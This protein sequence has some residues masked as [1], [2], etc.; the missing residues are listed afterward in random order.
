MSLGDLEIVERRP[1]GGGCISRTERIRVKSGREFCLKQH[2]GS[3]GASMLAA[4]AAGLRALWSE[5]GPRVPAVENVWSEGKTTYL[6]MEYIE[7]GSRGGSFFRDFGMKLARLHKE[8]K[9]TRFGFHMDNYIGSTPQPNTWSDTWISFFAEHRLG[10]QIRLARTK[11]LADKRMSE[12]VERI[13]S[14]LDSLLVEPEQASVLH[15]DLWGGN[16]LVDSAGTAVIIDPAVYYGHREADLAMTELFGG[17]SP[18]FYRAYQEEWPLQPGY[19]ERSDLYNLYHMLNHLNI[20]GGGYAG[21][22]ARICRKY[23]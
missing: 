1:L 4:E 15:G 8:R 9:E 12:D 23:R 11:G 14:R 6:L 19:S 22:V 17:F 10:Y 21:A 13:I 18:E 5:S 16:Y 3:E 20:F 7:S 2:D